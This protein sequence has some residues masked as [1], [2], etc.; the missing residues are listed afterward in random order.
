MKCHF[1]Q[2]KAALYAPKTPLC[3]AKVPLLPIKSIHAPTARDLMA[4]HTLPHFTY[5]GGNALTSY[6][7]IVR[8]P[9]TLI[10]FKK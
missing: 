9:K 8:Q 1:M 2:A 5:K 4:E 7:V 10:Q 3:A 6:M